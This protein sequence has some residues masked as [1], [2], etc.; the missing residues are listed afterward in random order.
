VF[1]TPPKD[2]PIF[3]VEYWY[4][5]GSNV[6]KFKQFSKVSGKTNKKTW[7]SGCRSSTVGYKW[8]TLMDVVKFEFNDIIS[9]YKKNDSERKRSDSLFT[10]Y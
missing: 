8:V 5:R 2:A 10:I 9:L 6:K 3:L 7:V 1:G 4:I